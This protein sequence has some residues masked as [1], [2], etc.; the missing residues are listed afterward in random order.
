MDDQPFPIP[1]PCF[2]CAEF[3][4]RCDGQLRCTTCHRPVPEEGKQ[5]EPEAVRVQPDASQP[6]ASMDG[7][8]AFISSLLAGAPWL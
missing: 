7:I 1:K 4:E 8:T 2:G 5:T 6:A 3:L